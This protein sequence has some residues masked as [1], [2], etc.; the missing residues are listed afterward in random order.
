MPEADINIVTEDARSVE[1][2]NDVASHIAK[3][4]GR[5][6]TKLSRLRFSLRS[7]LLLCAILCLL[8][9]NRER[10]RQR[11]NRAKHELEQLGVQ[12]VDDFEDPVGPNVLW[13]WSIAEAVPPN[14]YFE[15]R[16]PFG[17]WFA[18][19]PLCITGGY[20]GIVHVA[21]LDE[22]QFRLLG[23]LIHLQSCW[24]KDVSFPARGLSIVATMAELKRLTIESP[25]LD[26][27]AVP[28]LLAA[29]QLEGLALLCPSMS[30]QAFKSLRVALPKC[31]IS[32]HDEKQM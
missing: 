12:L 9:G 22:R 18:E 3:V 2:V 11:H 20:W 14:G 5:M 4:A 28:Y 29:T 27:E 15:D 16:Y 21:T 24:L 17:K 13:M 32:T 23:D 8:L 10:I 25:T 1:V 7:L 6:K 26:D 31:E 30:Q 19:S